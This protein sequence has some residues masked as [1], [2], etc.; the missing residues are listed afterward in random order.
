MRLAGKFLMTIAIGIFTFIPPLADLATETHVFHEGW[1][2]HAR[3]HTV[4]LL[5]VTSSIGLVSLYYLWIRK[6]EERLNINLAG[7]LSCCV[8][9]AFFLSAS[10]TQLYGG[11]LSDIAG[12]AADGPFGING[13]VFAFTAASVLLLSGWAPCARRENK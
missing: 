5:G 1:L 4:W 12:A 13:N 3:M 9:G 11:R 7:A 2:P 8:Y 10:T 6:R